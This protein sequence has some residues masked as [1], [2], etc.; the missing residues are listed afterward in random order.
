VNKHEF[1]DGREVPEYINII[2]VFD[3]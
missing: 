2:A 1:E 3:N